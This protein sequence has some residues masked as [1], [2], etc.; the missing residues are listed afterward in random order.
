M[1]TIHVLEKKSIV[2]GVFFSTIL[3]KGSK[4]KILNTIFLYC[5]IDLKIIRK[6]AT[7]TVLL[8]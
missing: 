1:A 3:Y 7:Q 6:D 8:L 4:T 5:F 2:G